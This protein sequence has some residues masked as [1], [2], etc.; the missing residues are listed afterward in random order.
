[1]NELIGYV[2]PIKGLKDGIHKFDYAI[3]AGFFKAFENPPVEEA[4][5][6]FT[7]T[8][9]KKHDLIVLLFDFEG[10]VATICDR[11]LADIHLPIS[12]HERLLLKYSEETVS[13][14]PEVI[15]VHPE[16]P[17]VDVSGLVYEFICLALPLVKVYDCQSDPEPPCNQETLRYLQTEDGS[18]ENTPDEN[19]I[20]EALKKVDPT[21]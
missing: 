1:M 16:S 5:L 7:L 14:D 3:G 17:H 20:W 9:E 18:P 11:C 15:F 6:L 8:L 4:N 21:K 13:N 2:I 12:G 19:P 10:T